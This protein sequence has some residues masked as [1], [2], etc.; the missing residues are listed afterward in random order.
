MVLTAPEMRDM[1][2]LRSWSEYA[3][4][5][6]LSDGDVAQYRRIILAFQS[7][8]MVELAQATEEAIV[9]WLGNGP[10]GK[11]GRETRSRALRHFY[12]WASHHK[13]LPRDPTRALIV[14][15]KRP[16]QPREIEK[17]DIGKILSAAREMEDPRVAPALTLLY[18][19]GVRVGSLAGASPEDV[20]LVG[21]KIYWR[22][23]KRNRTYTSPLNDEALEAAR[24]LVELGDYHPFTASRRPTLIGVGEE[25][26]R[27]WLKAACDSAQVKRV[28]P[29]Q[30]RHA[31][32]TAIA[33][34]PN[35]EVQ[36]WVELMGHSGPDEFGKYA[37]ERRMRLH[38]AVAALIP[39]ASP[40]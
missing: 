37:D 29:G 34:D 21:R 32:A 19:T 18:L 1:D 36:T 16:G 20:D 11:W 22:A 9:S 15:R 33:N 24:T 30:F 39:P 31:F 23:A 14:G 2:L 5:H 4:A 17:V 28:S 35:V 6:G 3:M 13:H 8:L 27:Q 26:V 7:D 12:G 40:Q 10:S 38:A 25:R